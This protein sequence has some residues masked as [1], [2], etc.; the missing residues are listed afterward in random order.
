MCDLKKMKLVF[1]KGTLNVSTDVLKEFILFREMINSCVSENQIV[2]K[3]IN[4][5]DFKMILNCIGNEYYQASLIAWSNFE[6]YCD[7]LNAPA[8]LH[9]I[10]INAI[11]PKIN[12]DAAFIRSTWSFNH[13][14][15]TF[16]DDDDWILIWIIGILRWTI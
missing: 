7:Y 4:I 8:L 2:L 14:E 11:L 15:I 3:N 12:G 1:K 10:A 5:N 6:N 9:Q 16:N 13:V